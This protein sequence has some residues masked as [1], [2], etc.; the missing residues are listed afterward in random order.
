MIYIAITPNFDDGMVSIRDTYLN[1]VYNAGAIPILLQP[2]RDGEFI[3]KMCEEVDGFI[4]SGG[5]DLDPAMYGEENTASK[6]I[7]SVRDEFEKL[8]FDEAI[9][10]G[11]PILGICRGLQA[12]NVF[13]G[14][15]LCQHID[16]HVQE[17]SREIRTHSAS[18]IN[19][20][21]LSNILK[22][23]RVDVNSF[24]HQVTK[25]L[26]EGLTINAMSD[27]GYVEAFH[28]KDHPFLLGV[29][30]HPESYY[31]EC[32]TSRKIF[33]AFIDACKSK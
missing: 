27:D 30:W 3:K 31:N 14:G 9:K 21:L 11:K 26:A 23:E 7:C 22:S 8:L 5:A 18:V 15:S 25:R 20:T 16:G 17:E 24:H 6:N 29:Q 13:M 4:F 2:R 32:E 10:T 33:E 12:I 1:S 28:A 19:N